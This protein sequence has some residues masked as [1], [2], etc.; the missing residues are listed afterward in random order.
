MGSQE[1]DMTERLN[2][3]SPT[4]PF[5]TSS[6]PHTFVRVISCSW[7]AISSLIWVTNPPYPSGGSSASLAEK[8]CLLSCA[9]TRD[10]VLEGQALRDTGWRDKVSLSHPLWDLS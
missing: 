7:G 9:Q 2:N 6:F 4:E 5:G 3:N 1:S 10:S 8:H